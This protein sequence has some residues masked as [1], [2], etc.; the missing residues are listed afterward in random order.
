MRANGAALCAVLL[1]QA[2]FFEPG[3]PGNTASDGAVD[4]HDSG[5]GSGTAPEARLI[6]HAYWCG[7]NGTS[8]MDVTQYAISTSNIHDGDLVLFIANIDNGTND[9]WA[10]PTGYTKLY[11]SFYDGGDGQTYV[12]GYKIVHT[13]TDEGL[14]YVEPYG[15]GVASA[16]AVIMLVGVTGY[17]PN[18][19]I[20]A[21]VTSLGGTATDPAIIRSRI[22]TTRPNTRLILAGGADWLTGKPGNGTDGNTT[23]DQPPNFALIDGITDGGGVAFTW[24]SQLIATRVAATA[25]DTGAEDAKMMATPQIN[26]EPWTVEVAIA[27]AP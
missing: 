14:S 12:A 25:G 19:P 10:L 4:G 7:G 27:P 21:K 20:D 9:I 17:D 2:C 8:G 11:E 23:F 3:R 22:T 16:C 15:N 26:G 5:S 6:E 18:N 13:A 1:L 24:T